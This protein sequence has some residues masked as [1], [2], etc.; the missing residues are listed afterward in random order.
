[1]PRNNETGTFGDPIAEH[2]G[3]DIEFE[4]LRKETTISPGLPGNAADH[5]RRNL[6]AKL[7][8]PLAGY[9]QEELRK[10]GMNFAIKHCLGDAEDIRA[11]GIGAMLAQTSD[12]FVTVPGL[13]P[14]ELEVLQN[15]FAHRWSQPWTMYL[16][17]ALCSLSAAV[18]GMGWSPSTHRVP[19][20]LISR[21]VTDTLYFQMKRWSTAPIYSTRNNLVSIKRTPRP[22][23]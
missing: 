23:G 13:R 2:L 5:A 9:T 16:V 17:V 11:F 6:N 18:Q 8:N 3:R 1:M 19:L 14:E 15:E 4:N 12:E 7:A 20:Q 22:T 21:F 10:Q